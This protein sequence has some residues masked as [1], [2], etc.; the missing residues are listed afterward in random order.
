MVKILGCSGREFFS[1]IAGTTLMAFGLI[2]FAA[3][4]GLVAGGFTGISIVVRE[5][6]NLIFGYSI[7]LWVS[8]VVLNIPLFIVSISQRG[9]GVARKSIYAVI[10]NSAM[11]WVLEMMPNLFYTGGDFLLASVFSGVL[12]GAGMGMVLRAFA[13]TGGTDMLASVIKYKYHHYPITGLIII[14]DGIIIL[15][16]L[17]I[18]GIQKAMYAMISV[19][20]TSRAIN[21]IVE[22]MYFAKA[23]FILSDKNQEISQKI[24]QVLAR[25]NTGISARGMY[26]KKHME[27][28]LVVVARKEVAVLRKIVKEIDPKA[29]IIIADVREVL[30]EGFVEEYDMLTI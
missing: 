3:P 4:T 20:I 9:F 17:F 22:G 25:G 10:W 2:W 28:L 29:F 13:T 11:M 30:G 1:I 24:F 6:S 8:N 7:P 18:F 21:Y 27:M 23:A 12:T 16:G 19:L 15:S 5:M 26:T 14:I